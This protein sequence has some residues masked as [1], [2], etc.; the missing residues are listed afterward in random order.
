MLFMH[1]TDAYAREAQ[2][3]LNIVSIEL[4]TVKLQ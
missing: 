1:V 3:Q 2:Q 4:V